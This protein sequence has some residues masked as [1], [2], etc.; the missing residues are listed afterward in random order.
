MNIKPQPKL[1]ITCATHAY[2]DSMVS[3]R[4]MAGLVKRPD[5]G[6]GSEFA[7]RNRTR[8]LKTHP[9]K[10]RW[11][12]MP[13]RFQQATH[14]KNHERNTSQPETK[15]ARVAAGRLDS[16]FRHL[17]EQVRDVVLPFLAIYMTSMGYSPA[18]SG[19]AIA[20]YGV[21]SLAAALIGGYLADRIGRRRTIMLSMFPWRLP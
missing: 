8:F 12:F 19:M 16:F 6:W 14:E 11:V 5:S 7:I 10:S 17:P 2:V 9:L 20:A 18:Q 3:W 1:S 21:G 13:H 4:V 15:P